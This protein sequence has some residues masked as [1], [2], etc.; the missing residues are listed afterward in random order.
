[1]ENKYIKLI[2]LAE[3][4]LNVLLLLAVFTLSNNNFMTVLSFTYFI[5]TSRALNSYP[6]APLSNDPS[7]PQAL[8][9][10][11]FITGQARF[12][13]RRKTWLID[14]LAVYPD[15]S[16]Y[17]VLFNTLATL[18]PR[19]FAEITGLQSVEI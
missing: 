19:I 18:V 4:K 10:G 11:H 1:M 8:T 2:L 7:D 14:Q 12:R 16:I 15:S 13:C 6:L 3:T 9:P 5:D 17:G